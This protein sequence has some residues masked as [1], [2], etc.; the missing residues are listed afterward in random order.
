MKKA[1]LY[2]VL[3][4]TFACSLGIAAQ[5]EINRSPY[6][7]GENL[8]YELKYK[9]FLGIPFTVGELNFTVINNQGAQDIL[10]HSIAKSKGT[11]VALTGRK[12]LQDYKSSVDRNALQIVKTVK[13]DV[14]GKRVRNSEANFDYSERR[15][16]YIE[17]DPNDPSRP[18]RRVASTIEPGTQDMVTAVYMLRQK[19]LAIGKRFVFKVSDSGLVYDVPVNVTGRER[20][21]SIFGKVWCWKIEPEVFGKGRFIEQK[22]SLTFWI[23]DDERRVPVYADLSTKYGRVQIK[24]RKSQ[25]IQAGET[26]ENS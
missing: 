17:T 21:K 7:P 15:V 9:P 8:V 1:T 5:T 13:K 14:Q 24:L 26:S 22:G 4:L 2:L 18:P 19:P 11:L 3:F 20:K 6:E 10:I 23:T 16:V 25:R 12:Y